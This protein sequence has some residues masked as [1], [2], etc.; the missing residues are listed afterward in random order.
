VWHKKQKAWVVGIVHYREALIDVDSWCR[1]RG[2]YVDYIPESLFD[3]FEFRIPFTDPT[4]EN[5]VAYDYTQDSL[6]KPRLSQLPKNL[7]AAL[8]DFQKVGV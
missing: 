2:I 4:K 6:Q 5:V 1:P 8:Y 3:L 7:M